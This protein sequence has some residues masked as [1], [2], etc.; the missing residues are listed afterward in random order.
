MT[1][2]HGC[3]LQAAAS[4]KQTRSEAQLCRSAE[5]LLKPHHI[6][7]CSGECL[8]VQV[9]QSVWG[10]ITWDRCFTVWA[11]REVFHI[12]K[13]VVFPVATYG[14]ESWTI[15]KAE[16]RRIDAFKLWCWRRLLRVPW[17][18][19]RFSQYILKEI[20]PG[21]SLE[22][23]R[24]VCLQSVCNSGLK[25]KVLDDE[26]ERGEWKKENEKLNILKLRSWH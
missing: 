21:I 20:S 23:L 24:L 13:G 18:A 25:Q 17:I 5:A 6:L 19:R 11:T 4:I 9:Y 2:A 15:K 3:R 7:P 16:C 10:G 14:Y 26:S 8:R 12:V 22:V 1:Y